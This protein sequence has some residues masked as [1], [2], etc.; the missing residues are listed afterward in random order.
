MELNHVPAKDAIKDSTFIG[1]ISARH[2]F[3]HQDLLTS[4]LR[5]FVLVFK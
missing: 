2:V 5:K 4:F 3:D 1:L